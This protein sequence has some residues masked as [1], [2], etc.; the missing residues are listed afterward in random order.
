MIG[1]NK[2]LIRGI[3]A[4]IAVHHLGQVGVKDPHVS[5]DFRASVEP[6]GADRAGDAG[7]RSWTN[8]PVILEKWIADE[9]LSASVAPVC[10]GDGCALQLSD[11]HIFVAWHRSGMRL[12]DVIGK[13][14]KK[15]KSNF[16]VVRLMAF[17]NTL[18]NEIK[19]LFVFAK[20]RHLFHLLSPYGFIAT[21]WLEPTTFRSLV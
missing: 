14:K 18:S 11:D 19:T 5:H 16:T 4:A 6:L 12:L 2:N 17:I 9:D 13:L 1:K 15:I 10:H 21:G 7:P 20:A 3:A 8:A